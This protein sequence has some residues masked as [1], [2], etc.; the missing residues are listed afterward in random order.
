MKSK[1]KV[2]KIIIVIISVICFIIIFSLLFNCIFLSDFLYFDN[3]HINSDINKEIKELVLNSFKDLFLI[4][5]FK[6][7]ENLY[8]ATNDRTIIQLDENADVGKST[9]FI[10]ERDFMNNL[11]INESG[12]YYLIVKTY[13]PKSYFCHITICETENGYKISSFGLDI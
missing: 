5:G 3:T 4:T 13:F 11:S 2:K 6:N 9:F 7:S 12:E 8:L 1:K 10:I